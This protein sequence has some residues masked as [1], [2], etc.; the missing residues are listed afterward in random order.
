MDS[1]MK[2]EIQIGWDGSIVL[3]GITTLVMA[4]FAIESMGLE[5]PS[6]SRCELEAKLG[7]FSNF[8]KAIENDG[9]FFFEY[10]D[11]T[12]RVSANVMKRA[13]AE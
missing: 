3:Q 13:V 6:K 4:Y 10:E 5:F 8:K 7:G 2:Y 11:V 12:G 1:V 9:F